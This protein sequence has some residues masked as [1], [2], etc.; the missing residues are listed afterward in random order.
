MTPQRQLI[1]E[2]IARSRG[3]IS[4]EQ[5]H[6]QV[7][8]DY[9]DVNLSTVYRT[10]EQLEGLGYVRHTHFH[11][12]RAQFERTDEP[13]HQHLVCTT[14]GRDQELEISV[15]EPLQAEL[16]RLHGFHANLSHTAIVGTCSTCHEAR[17]S[18]DPR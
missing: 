7:V 12:E 2:A 18:T 16:R 17:A 14:C 6:R 5:I 9:P 8:D 3:H 13:P 15:L 4:V 1:L 10:L 11:G